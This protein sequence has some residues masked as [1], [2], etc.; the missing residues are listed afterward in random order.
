M[1]KFIKTMDPRNEYDI[2]NV[3]VEVP[4]NDAELDALMEELGGFLLACG[5]RFDHLEVVHK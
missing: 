2:S 3:T 4:D 1:F 5:Y